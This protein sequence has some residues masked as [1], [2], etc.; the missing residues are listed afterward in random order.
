MSTSFGVLLLIIFAF[1]ILCTTPGMAGVRSR[2]ELLSLRCNASQ[3]NHGQRL[4]ITSLGL[5]RRG[6]LAGNHCRRRLL[7]AHSMT[8]AVGLQYASTPGEIPRIVGHRPMVVNKYQLIHGQSDGS[9][10]ALRYR[11]DVRSFVRS[12]VRTEQQTVTTRRRYIARYYV[13]NDSLT[14]I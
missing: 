5:R 1:Q 4:Q 13:R 2:D 6:Y 14:A 8:S 7:A 12:T 3:L 10:S 11:L 9:V